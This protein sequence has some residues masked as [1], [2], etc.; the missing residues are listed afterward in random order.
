MRG[1]KSCPKLGGLV[2]FTYLCLFLFIRV[3]FRGPSD[4]RTATRLARLTSL[5]AVSRMDAMPLCVPGLLYRARGMPLATWVRATLP[6]AIPVLARYTIGLFGYFVGPETHVVDRY[7]TL[8]AYNPTLQL[9]QSAAPR[10]LLLAGE[11]GL[12]RSCCNKSLFVSL[13]LGEIA[14]TPQCD[15]GRA[16]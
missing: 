8:R 7:S 15:F 1:S 11:D 10:A 16:S 3:V 6:G 2:H 9:L 5:I 12:L 14:P 13:P 4:A